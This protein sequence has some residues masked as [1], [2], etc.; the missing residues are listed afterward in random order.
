MSVNDSMIEI[1]IL[2]HFKTNHHVQV[3]YILCYNPSKFYDTVSLC[4]H[5][6][7]AGNLC[8]I[9]EGIITG[10]L[11]HIVED[12][13]GIREILEY[14]L[15]D[16]GFRFQSSSCLQDFRIK[17]KTTLPDLVLLDIRL[18]DGDGRDLCRTMKASTDY[19]SIPIILLSA[20][21]DRKQVMADAKP[22]E[23]IPKPFDIEMLIQ[24]I[25]EKLII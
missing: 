7:A 4:K 25:R 17:I 21:A 2:S 22:N 19:C 10:A 16:S 5:V 18:P 8:D 11:I 24:T 14:V 9:M 13:E 15:T 1:H 23:F 6:F 3:S 20:D 12:D